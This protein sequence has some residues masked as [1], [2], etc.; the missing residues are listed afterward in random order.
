M[1]NRSR[2]GFTLVELLVVT[3]IIA[4][5]LGILLPTIGRARAAADKVKCASQ[6][7]QIGQFAAMYAGTYNNFLP[8]GYIRYESY[9][10]GNSVLWFMQKAPFNT[11]GPV[12]LGYL[13][14]SNII[15]PGQE[16]SRQVWYC[17]SVPDNWALSY[18]HPR[19]RWVDIP[20]SN[21]QAMA[22][23]SSQIALKMGYSSRPLLTS[24]FGDEQ[25][26]SW[27]AGPG[28][29]AT[30]FSAPAYFNTAGM[31]GAKLRSTNVFKG[32]A[33]VFDFNEDP[34]LI[35]GVHKNGVNVLY[36]S[37]AVKWIPLEMFKQEMYSGQNLVIKIN[38]GPHQPNYTYA[39]DW[40]ALGRMW[41]NFDRQQ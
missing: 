13:F 2:K 39:G 3:G 7:R 37:Y 21:Q 35:N 20:I 29:T 23:P 33:I 36:A 17:P 32:K 5:L 1:F 34:R 11:N 10:P 26:L 6:L 28:G 18:N 25:T 40:F 30:N 41:E 15:K 27:A 14:S 22:W 24:K 8:I 38:G 9:A 31:S 19:N 4:I 16:F 12:G